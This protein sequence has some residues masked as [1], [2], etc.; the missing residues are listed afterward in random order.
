MSTKEIQ[1]KLVESMRHWQEIEDASVASTTKVM[2]KTGH[3]LIKLVMEIIRDDSK[4]HRMVQEYIAQITEGGTVALSIED[5]AEVWDGIEKHIAIEKQM[6]DYVEE[7]LA[8]I[9][10]RHMLMQ[11]Y[12][13][14]YLREDERKHDHLLEAL[15]KI[16]AGA[17]P[18]A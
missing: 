6:V 5:L 8:S 2:E 15:E 1:A 3:P 4:K 16:K 17:Y 14:S 10:G 18:Y 9:K 13:L 7:A 11:E 12:L